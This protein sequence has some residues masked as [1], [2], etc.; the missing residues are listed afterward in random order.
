MELLI[1][2]DGLRRASAKEIIAII[3]YYGYSRQDRKSKPHEPITARLVADFL[4]IAGIDRLIVIDLHAPQI[5]GFFKH[6]V[7]DISAVPMFGQYFKDLQKRTN[8]DFVV[9]SPDHGGVTRA[10]R[11]TKIMSVRSIEPQIAIID[12]RRPKPNEA[13]VM[14]IIGDVKGKSCIIIDDI[15]DTANTLIAA[16]NA[17]IK[18]GALE[19]YAAATHPILS[20]GADKKIDESV[21]KE[22]LVTDSIPLRKTAITNKIKVLSVD[23]LIQVAIDKI[24]SG[25]SL[26]DIY[27]EYNQ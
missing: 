21:I 4:T 24:E 26:S 8:K 25:S 20:G 6:P 27:N 3:P 15:C 17:L 9:V 18:A 22:L 11:L 12:K 5:Q 13:E 14:N 16:S 23:H 2:V 7:D 10:R 19:V 1:F